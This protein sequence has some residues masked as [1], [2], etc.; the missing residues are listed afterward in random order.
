MSKD[1]MKPC[2]WN[3]KYKREI[4]CTRMT[5]DGCSWDPAVHEERV[6]ELRDRE[7]RGEVVKKPKQSRTSYEAVVYGIEKA[8]REKG[9][10]LI[11]GGSLPFMRD[12]YKFFVKTMAE[13]HPGEFTAR[14]HD[15]F[16]LCKNGSVIRF[17]SVND[18]Q[19]ITQAR[20]NG[21]VPL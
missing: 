6:A 18:T 10:Y 8:L 20:C 21:Y 16:I 17:A 13:L 12:H 4:W 5:C 9:R 15:W 19:T 11:I 7:Q 14:A 2:K 1:V 3:K